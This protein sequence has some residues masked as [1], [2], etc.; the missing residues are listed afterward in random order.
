MTQ[1][2]LS[3]NDIEEACN[4]INSKNYDNLFLCFSKHGNVINFFHIVK[5]T[6]FKNKETT[7]FKLQNKEFS[8]DLV[9]SRDEFLTNIP[10]NK[11]TTLKLD[12]IEFELSYPSFFSINEKQNYLTSI[13]KINGIKIKR[14]NIIPIANN[15]SIKSFKK[16]NEH[17]I[18]NY[19][20]EIDKIVIFDT[21][22]DKTKKIFNFN[23]SEIFQLI[24]YICKY[25]P[26][27]L[28]QLRLVLM[29]EGNFLYRDFDSIN[30]E[31]AQQY[32]KLL[33]EMMRKS[34]EHT[35][36]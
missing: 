20:S 15:L 33:E 28:Q 5:N 23:T 14:K 1:Y 8:G 34:N 10:L 29:K 21:S 12:N 11:K 32:Y 31:E 19:I 7:S 3:Y 18:D 22:S 30:V 17:I 26:K 27:Y 25:E 13:K 6:L 9:L 36:Y 35:E 2:S 24:G 16:I 4:N